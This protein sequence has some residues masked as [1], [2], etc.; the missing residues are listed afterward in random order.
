[1]ALEKRNLVLVGGAG[2]VCAGALDGEVVED[3]SLVDGGF[4]LGNQL[5]PPHVA[6]PLGR[7][8]DGDLGA[9]LAACV[10]GVLVVGREVDCRAVSMCA[11]IVF[12][13][14]V[15]TYRIAR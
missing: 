4:G 15:S 6:V 3:G 14:C 13:T 11:V 1:M 5:C 9:L 12:A 7:A 2:H 10:A 8:V